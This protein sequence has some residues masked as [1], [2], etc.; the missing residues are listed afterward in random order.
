MR[1]ERPTGGSNLQ[2]DREEGPRKTVDKYREKLKVPNH[3]P[4]PNARP[5]VVSVVVVVIS[6]LLFLFGSASAGCL[7]CIFITSLKC[8]SCC[9]RLKHGVARRLKG[10][11]SIDVRIFSVLVV[12]FS[13]FWAFVCFRS[14]PCRTNKRREQLFFNARCCCCLE[15]KNGPPSR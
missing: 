8:T 13:Q 12:T 15:W 5:R 14:D 11:R 6:L 10:V 4:K 7:W 9:S 3:H 1:H 2:Q